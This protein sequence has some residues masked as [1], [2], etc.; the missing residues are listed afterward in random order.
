LKRIKILN[1]LFFVASFIFSCIGIYLVSTKDILI[2]SREIFVFF[3]YY[4]IT[5]FSITAGY[6]RYFSHRSF[7]T[8]K[9]MECFLLFFGAATFSNS[10][11]KWAKDHRSHHQHVDHEKLDP[12][13]ISKGF[14][15]AHIGW[16]ILSDE[17]NSTESDTRDLKSS[18]FTLLQDKYILLLSIFS[19]LIIPCLIGFFMGSFLFGFF[20]LGF[21]R[22]FMFH[23]SIFLINSYCH[24]FG[25]RPISNISAGNSIL[26]AF[27]TL[28][29]GYHHYH[30]SYPLD[31]RAGRRWYDWDPN[32]WALSLLERVSLVRDLRRQND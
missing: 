11:L 13:S 17:I 6:H 31:Y 8:S 24:Y 30:H 19:G 2:S 16:A 22:V 4:Y 28:G 18:S 25:S 20:I 27:L 15:Y 29:D 7:K 3:F 10:A 21:L 26:V 9:W 1:L 32:K 5:S 23:H 14:L 12:Y